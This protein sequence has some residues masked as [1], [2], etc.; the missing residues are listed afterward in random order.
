MSQEL[1]VELALAQNARKPKDDS[2]KKGAMISKDEI[3][4]ASKM[5]KDA[6]I[7]LKT[8]TPSIIDKTIKFGKYKGK[9]YN[10]VYKNDS[11]WMMWAFMNVQGFED[12][13]KAANFKE[14]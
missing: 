7:Q 13:A 8:D 2:W 5:G 1:E 6:E 11:R 9:T 12:K 14:L 3:I 10:W 4:K